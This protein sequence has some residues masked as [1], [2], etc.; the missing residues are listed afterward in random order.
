MFP[1]LGCAQATCH[2]GPSCLGG[3]NVSYTDIRGGLDASKGAVPLER[4]YQPVVLSFN[5]KDL[6]GLIGGAGG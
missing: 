5:L 3:S 6:Y 4:I 1:N 2:T